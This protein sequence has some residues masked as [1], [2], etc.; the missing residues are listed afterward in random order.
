ME[1]MLAAHVHALLLQTGMGKTAKKFESEFDSE[2]SH[3][4][5]FRLRSPFFGSAQSV[6]TAPPA[7][8]RN[9][10]EAVRY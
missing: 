4:P 2:V 10:C 9:R 8:P 5:I 6:C 3:V 1:P 7:G